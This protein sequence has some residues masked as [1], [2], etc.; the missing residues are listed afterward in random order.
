VPEKSLALFVF[1]GYVHPTH[2]ISEL[3]EADLIVR[4]CVHDGE[5]DA[6]V[7]VLGEDILLDLLPRNLVL[8]LG[9]RVFDSIGIAILEDC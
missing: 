8:V 3:R 6:E 7:Y 1:K 4:V 9:V 5:H 2:F